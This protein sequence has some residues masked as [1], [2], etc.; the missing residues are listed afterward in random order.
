[1]LP[2][3]L[4]SQGVPLPAGIAGRPL[5]ASFGETGPERPAV[6]ESKAETKAARVL[7]GA[8]TSDAKYIRE[9]SIADTELY[10]DLRSDPKEKG[11]HD[12]A[13]VARA[14][15]LRQVA[16]ASVTPPVYRFALRLDG[17]DNYDVRLRST[18]WL[19]VVDRAGL[20]SADRA[21]VAD[22][23]HVVDLR[24]GRGADKP[25]QVELVARPHGAPVVLEGT[26][27]GRPLR[28]A[29]IRSGGEGSPAQ[30]LPFLLPGVDDLLHPFAPP[31]PAASAIALWLVPA[32]AG[33][34]DVLDQE[35]RESLKALGYLH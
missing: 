26:R 1:V 14:R 19:E 24:L 31:P 27:D 25:R 29:E 34:A 15:V 17:A 7:Y 18:G 9:L 30:R 5:E 33:H 8:R 28:P 6:F 4:K 21:E 23:G 32:R 20:R 35:T 2:T 10:F 22:G 12:P 13:A 11:G 3:V 16:E